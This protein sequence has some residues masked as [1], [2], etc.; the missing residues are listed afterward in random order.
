LDLARMV[1][2]ATQIYS[3]SVAGQALPALDPFAPVSLVWPR[4][5]P[6]NSEDRQRDA[7]TLATLSNAGQ[8]SRA[9]AVRVIS[10]TYDIADVADELSRIA[11]ER[12]EPE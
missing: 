1:L 12:K 8:I 11:A 2:H 10:T 6:P 3:V 7:Q 4:W 9:T 5:Y